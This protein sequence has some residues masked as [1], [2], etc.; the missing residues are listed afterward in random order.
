MHRMFAQPRR[1]WPCAAPASCGALLVLA[2][3]PASAPAQEPAA[4]TTQPASTQHDESS[5]SQPTAPSISERKYYVTRA[6]SATPAPDPPVYVHRAS[7]LAEWFGA[8]DAASLSWLDVGIEQNTRYEHR[9]NYYPAGNLNDNRFLMRNRAYLGIREI[10]DPLRFGFEFQDARAFGNDFPEITQDVD[11]NDLLQAFGE[12]YFQNA[13]G[14]KHPLSFRAGRQSFD[15][16]NRRLVARNGFRNSTNAFDGF[17]LR[18][19]DDTTSWEINVLAA[20]PVER[21]A[22]RLDQP[23]DERWFYGLTGYFRALDPGILFKPYYFVLDEDRKGFNKYDRELHTV[24]LN[25]FGL[26]GDSGF[27][28]DLDGA[29]QFGKS[30]RRNHRAFATH[31]ELGYTITHDW[32]PRLAAF[33]DYAS[34][35]RHPFDRTNERFD[36]LFGASHMF[37][38]PTDMFTWENLIQPGLRWT[39]K[40]LKNLTLESFYRAYWLASD[41]DTWSPSNVRARY[42]RNGDFLGHGLDVA[43]IYQITRHWTIEIGYAHL[44]AGEFIQNLL[45]GD[46]SDFF[47][48][49]TTV[50]L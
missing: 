44:T 27:D 42:G 49:Q 10:V 34:G 36:R 33:V 38:A 9:Q 37:Y 43:V 24:G 22:R 19:G 29:W 5:T 16:V 15:L 12:L 6:I 7:A 2:L 31:A 32:K 21:F 47:Y 26:L 14:E 48:V 45:N 8:A 23:D 17:R 20:M 40:P 35:D 46:D 4:V 18:A 25:V 13:L 11:E 41:S 1:R 30:R 3:A 28:Y 50:R 39:V